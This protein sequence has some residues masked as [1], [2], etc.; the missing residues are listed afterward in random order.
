MTACWRRWCLLDWTSRRFVN[1]FLGGKKSVGCRSWKSSSFLDPRKKIGELLIFDY[2]KVFSFLVSRW[3]CERAFSAP[4]RHDKIVVNVNRQ[5]FSSCAQCLSFWNYLLCPTG[6]S[7]RDWSLLCPT[8]RS[9]R[10][11][12]LMCPTGHSVRDLSLL[13]HTGRS[14]RDWYLLCPI[15]RSVRDWSLLCPVDRS[16]RYSSLLCPTGRSVRD[17][18]PVSYWSFS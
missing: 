13:C 6:R 16:V 4:K 12:S 11:W 8:G 9:V 2:T 14:V 1:I 17:S 3:R 5:L 18:S 10:D 7:V 15:G